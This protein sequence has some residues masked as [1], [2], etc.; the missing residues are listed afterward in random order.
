ML[1]VQIRGPEFETLISVVYHYNLSSGWEW[2]VR[3]DEFLVL[4]C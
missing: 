3:R 4:D 1:V 2:E